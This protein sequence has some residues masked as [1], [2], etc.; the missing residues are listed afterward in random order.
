MI[1][2]IDIN[3][4]ITSTI[5]EGSKGTELEGIEIIPYDITEG[6]KRPSLK[7]DVTSGVLEHLNPNYLNRSLT[8]RVY[9]FASDVIRYKIENLKAQYILE[10]SL[11][12]GIKVEN[13]NIPV[14]DI[15]SNIIDSVLEVEFSININ[16]E[17]SILDDQEYEL[18]EDIEINM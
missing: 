7:I 12:N 11:V 4:H 16:F 9:F 14:Y 13:L 3:K 8:V 2:L 10:M 5:R 1:N 6:F 17:K 18:M 15:D